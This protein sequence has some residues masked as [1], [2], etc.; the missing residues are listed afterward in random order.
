MGL[1]DW[2][3]RAASAYSRGL[4][5][6][7]AIGRALLHQPAVLLMDEPFTGLDEQARERLESLLA[8]LRDG[9]RTVLVTS[10]DLDAGLRLADSV[11]VLHRGPSSP[12]ETDGGAG[13]RRLHHL[14]PGDHRRGRHQRAPEGLVVRIALRQ[15]WI[16]ARKDLRCEFRSASAVITMVLLGFL[17]VLVFS[18]S[19]ESGAE[20]TAAA[21][22][23]VL[24]AAFLFPG[25]L[26]VGR[27]FEGEK[28]AQCLEGLL[29]CPVDRGAIYLGKLARQPGLVFRHRTGGVGLLHGAL[30]RRAWDCPGSPCWG[31]CSW[32]P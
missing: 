15:A 27:S 1:T 4:L 17:V 9:R 6:R 16:I 19:L 10:H 21:R 29:L 13:L 18:F 32:Q 3:D 5:Q 31:S 26:A 30:R 8:T 2:A 20:A 22:S 11:A 12:G 14:L 7:L 28:E 25:L 23:G 24:W